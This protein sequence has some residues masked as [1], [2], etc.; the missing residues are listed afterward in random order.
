M[1]ADWNPLLRLAVIL[2]AGVASGRVARRA[3]LPAVTGQILVG[4]VLGPVLHLFDAEALSALAPV[5]HFA[6]GLMAVA[7]G[8]HLHLRRLRNAKKRLGLLLAAE[9]LFVPS[10]VGA[11]VALLPGGS[12]PFAVL[13]AAIALSTAPATILAIVRETR[14]KGVFVK[15]LVAGVALDNIAAIT[16]FEVA[17]AVVR[18][19]LDPTL[20]GG[21]L[22]LI[23]LP[24]RVLVLSALLGVLV[25]GLLIVLTRN[26][27]RPDR[28]ATLSMVA[29]LLTAGV[30]AEVPYLSTLLS[31]LFLGVVLANLT[32]EKEE[33]GHRVFT[34]FEPAIFAIFFTL[35][36]ME[37]D[38][39]YVMRGGE[40]ALAVFALRFAGKVLAAGVAMR[41]AGATD[42]VRRYLGLALMPQAGLAV[43][44]MLLVT[45]DPT[46][47]PIAN[48]FLAVVLTLVALNEIVG[49]L[50]ARF[51]LARSGDLGKDRARLID[52]LHEE[53]ITTDL[54]AASME[55]AIRQLVDLLVTSH[56]LD[57]DR[58]HLLAAVLEREALATTRLGDG[59]AI[60]HGEIEVGESI[61]GAMG[62]SHEGLDL[63]APDG[64]P[65][66]CMILLA[67]PPSERTRHLEVLAAFARAIGADRQVQQQLYRATT[68]AHA[69]ELLHAEEEA[70]DFNYFLDE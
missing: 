25:G 67:T 60:P 28:L 57:V 4:I 38:F 44:L 19:H 69:Y 31:C 18:A 66:H 65:V 46:F 58:E 6:L 5:T 45:E 22:G 40:I 24:V 55:D 20:G 51:A 1:P 3:G 42:R 32:P 15:T 52:F 48:L 23:V 12:W 41:L 2:V 50:L 11:G 16:L 33:I 17:H 47:A 7:V 34:N 62:V 61:L 14:S 26:V 59:L 56:G 37:L 49:P 13:L 70:E 9:V 21:G 43:G 54:H 36:G 35:A 64:R 8:S 68:P 27:V 39:Q 30:A 63:D 53:N 10:L 29:I